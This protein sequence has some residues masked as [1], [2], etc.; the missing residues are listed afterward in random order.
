MKK[1]IAD[2]QEDLKRKEAKWCQTQGRLRSQIEMLV[3]ENTDL[4]EE[5]KVMERFRLDA[6]KRAEASESSTRLGHSVSAPK[7]DEPVV[8][9]VMLGDAG[10]SGGQVYRDRRGGRPS[11]GGARRRG[12]Y[13]SERRASVC[14]MESSGGGWCWGPGSVLPAGNRSC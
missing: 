9:L 8:G 5:V 2:L 4:R 13:C 1:Q 11:A 10:Y 3:R 14:R 6:W 7:K 12:S